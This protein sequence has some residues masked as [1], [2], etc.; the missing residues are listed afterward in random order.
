MTLS[1]PPRRRQPFLSRNWSQGVSRSAEGAQPRR[2]SEGVNGVDHGHEDRPSKRP[3]LA[4]DVTPE[5]AGA[6]AKNALPSSL[7]HAPR[8]LR[9]NVVKL[10]HKN[11]ER[12]LK[13]SK[14]LINV[15]GPAHAHDS[16]TTRASCKITILDSSPLSAH[17]PP[18]VCCM[19]QECTI[20]TFTSS[21]GSRVARVHLDEPFL[22]PE[23]SLRVIREDNTRGLADN[24]RLDVELYAGDDGEW[25]PLECSVP[26]ELN[27]QGTRRWVLLACLNNL[28]ERRRESAD[29][30][31]HQYTREELLSTEFAADIDARWSTG[32][33]DRHTTPDSLTHSIVVGGGA[34]LAVL[35]AVRQNGFITPED[36]V[37]GE[38]VGDEFDPELTPNR[39]LRTRANTTVYNIKQLTDKAHGKAKKSRARDDGHV[40][41]LLPEEILCLDSYRCLACGQPH[42]SIKFLRTHLALGHPEYKCDLR[43]VNGVHQFRV[44]H[45]YERYSTPPEEFQF[46]RPA[47]GIK[48]DQ[49]VRQRGLER[50][51]EEELMPFRPAPPVSVCQNRMLQRFSS[52]RVLRTFRCNGFA[53]ARVSRG[54]KE[55]CGNAAR[56]PRF[57]CRIPGSQCT[58]R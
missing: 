24:Y 32:L 2:R 15:D 46:A 31:L 6:P 37:D 10:A 42:G 35:P 49:I 43:S 58:T 29:L 56:G 8:S 4:R 54:R 30:F 34:E 41:Y 36:V 45:N 23:K 13:L 25:P 50:E 40:S 48:L 44:T 11:S 3:R 38:V 27:N 14:T 47:E 12:K 5:P 20:R 26:A 28:F 51:R 1:T 57:S 16:V 19:T 18:V 21:F 53:N 39:A 17:M 7:P 22:I 9:V 33:E 52:A 55:C